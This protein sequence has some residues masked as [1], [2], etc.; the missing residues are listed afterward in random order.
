MIYGATTT[1]T[2]QSELHAG[3]GAMPD[4]RLVGNDHSGSHMLSGKVHD[5][6]RIMESSE[7]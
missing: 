1:M 2:V 6:V 4:G 5:K 7:R 3:P